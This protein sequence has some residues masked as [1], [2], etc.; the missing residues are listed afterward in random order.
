MALLFYNGYMNL[1]ELRI[2]KGLTQKEAS[3]I[4][5]I[6]LRT[7]KRV[8]LDESHYKYKDAFKLISS[9]SIEKKINLS[10]KRIMVIGA[11]YVGFSL[12]VLLSEKNEVTVIDIN[13]EKIKQINAR[14]PIFRDEE[15]AYFLKN[16]ELNLKADTLK[17]ENIVGQDYVIIALPTNYIEEKRSY[18]MSVITETIKV[19]RKYNKTAL[20]VIKSTS[21]IGYTESLDDENIVFCPEFLR[22][23]QA[24][25]DN[26]YPSRIIIGGDKSNKKVK[27]FVQLLL[28]AA[29]N[30]PQVLYMSSKEA[31][32]VK[33]FSNT[34]LAMRVA[35]FNELDSLANSMNMDS[36]N[37]VQGVSLDPRIG[38]YYNNPSFGYGGYCL[39]K[40]TQELISQM[41][42]VNNNDLLSSIERS[43]KTRKEYIINDISNKFTGNVAGVFSLVAK[44]K[45][46]NT[47]FSAIFD[48]IHGLESRGIEVI[49]FDP[50]K[51]S[52][53]EFK[54]RCDL[55]IVNRYSKELDD[56]KN[57]TYSRDLFMRD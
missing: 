15:I 30:H 35:Y 1:K 13:E 18:D 6:P 8:E 28:N 29:L 52:L 51:M 46:D 55:I 47:R 32:A 44:S 33:L 31:E 14:K 39:P 22:E 23:G 4:T 10:S 12:S 20:I 53:D 45:S 38:D 5:S 36:K 27:E 40:D 37:I 50:N 9:Y 42:N 21:Y 24:L 49:I 3:F 34:Y 17:K 11:G 19:I 25:K 57:K 26:L 2:S 48:I 16:K 56:V 54:N 41:Q 43:N 7:Y